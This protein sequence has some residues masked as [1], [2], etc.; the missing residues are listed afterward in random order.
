MIEYI[1][2]LLKTGTETV[3]FIIPLLILIFAGL[4]LTEVLFQ[5]GV[6]KRFEVIGKPLMRLANLP[7]ACAISF[8][9][10]IGSHLTANAM[11][12]QLRNDNVIKDR[13]VLL[14]SILNTIFV[15]I[16]EIKYHFGIIIPTLGLY[17]GGFYVVIMWLG[18]IVLITVVIL[19]GILFLP[20]RN[21]DRDECDKK[22]HHGDTET[23]RKNKFKILQS[24]FNATL[25]TFKKISIMFSIATFIIFLLINIGIFDIIITVI[26]PSANAVGIP[27]N[28]IPA[29]TAYI[30]SPLVGYPMIGAL[31][32][33]N[34]ISNH[35]AIIAL[36]FGSMFM[37]PILYLKLYFPQ[38]VAIFGFKL[39]M[40]RGLI[41]MSLFML[42][43]GII[44]ILFLIF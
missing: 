43:R 32:E 41:S 38:W 29:L 30:A 10:A 36:L 1:N 44:L 25:K 33:S 39:G 42:T 21:W 24:S 34:E 26:E 40:I 7:P 3:S 27:A 4:F 18:T 14:A 8:V 22:I 15:P 5:W 2:L 35:E 20:K 19:A 16:K 11:L 31:I 13:E 37:L 12:Q 28:A 9:A 6:L 23:R 17:V